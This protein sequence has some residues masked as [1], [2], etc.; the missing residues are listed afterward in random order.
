MGIQI[1]NKKF[2][3]WQ[4]SYSISTCVMGILVIACSFFFTEEMILNIIELSAKFGMI[5][6]A[7]MFAIKNIALTHKRGENKITD[8]LRKQ[9]P[10]QREQGLIAFNAFVLHALATILLYLIRQQLNIGMVMYMSFTALVPTV[11]MLY[12]YIT[13]FKPVQRKVKGWKKTHTFGWVLFGSV[14]AHEL[15]LNNKLELTTIIATVLAIGTL[16]Y[17]FVIRFNNKRSRKQLL[18][19][20]SG[21]VLLVIMFLVNDV[22]G[23]DIQKIGLSENITVVAVESAE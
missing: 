21:F 8:F 1:K 11:M 20:V 4:V 10:M 7:I 22:I 16:L 19:T 13:S 14:I 5:A 12:L 18:I 23:K 15:L 9:L 6:L 2:S 17:G 3:F